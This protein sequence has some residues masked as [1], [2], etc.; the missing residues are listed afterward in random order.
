MPYVQGED[1]NQIIFFPESLDEYITAD[2]LVRVIE[3]YVDQLDMVKLAF[4]FAVCPSVGRPPYDPKDMLKLYLYGYLNRIRSSRRLEH[5]SHRNVELMWLLKKVTPDFKTIADFRKDNKRALKKVFRDFN[6]LCNQWDLFGKELVAVD[7]SKFRASN[8]KRNNYSKKKLERHLKYIDEKINDYLNELEEND[9]KESCDRRPDASEIQ[10]R[11]E[12]LRSRKEIYEEYQK[13]LEDSGK[14]ELSTT[15]PDARLMSNNNNNVDVSYNVQTTVDAKH[16]LVLDFKVTQKPNDFGQLDHMGLRAK[17]LFGEDELKL[18]A[19]KGYFNAKDIKHCVL[20]GITP[21]VSKQTYSNGT[22]DQDFYPEKFHYDESKDVYICP[23][24]QELSY[25]RTRRNRKGDIL[26]H[27]YRNGPACS[28]C[29]C[30]TRCTKSQK[31]RSIFRHVDQ[32]LLDTLDLK[33]QG[34]MELYKQRQMIVEHPFGTIKRS[35]G[36]YYF[37]TRGKRAVT[38]EMSLVFMAYNLRR[39]ISI[40]GVE[41]IVRRLKERREPALA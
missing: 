35:W 38:A 27:D 6:Q 31:G 39:V 24:G 5:E 15:D 17:K 26:G 40:L 20:H 8:S 19:D 7:G 29:A 36:A 11:I 41:D 33:I 30:K 37:L 16:K 12:Q 13:E 2:N 18:L 32:D 28:R 10:K 23:A 34:N 4:K 14:G 22:G 9:E 21:Y 25:A 1:R 3:A